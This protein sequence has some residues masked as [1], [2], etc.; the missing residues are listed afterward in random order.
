MSPCAKKGFQDGINVR[1][2]KDRPAVRDRNQVTYP[3]ASMGRVAIT[4]SF[5][6]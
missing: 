2:P 6:D 1:S 4:L 5:P 3:S